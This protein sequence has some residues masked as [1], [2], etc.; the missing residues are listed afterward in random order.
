MPTK[1]IVAPYG[2]LAFESTVYTRII[3]CTVYTKIPYN[4]NLH[5][6]IQPEHRIYPYNTE[7]VYTPYSV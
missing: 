2:A 4:L 6:R 7:I 3:R 1:N 5:A